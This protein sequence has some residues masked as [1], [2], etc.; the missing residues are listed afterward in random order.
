VSFGRNEPARAR[1]AGERLAMDSFDV[2]RR[3]TGGRS[4]LHDRELT[5][6]VVVPV[7]SLGGPRAT[8]RAVNEALAAALRSLGADVSL[9]STDTV[10]GL[11]AGP[12]FRAPVAGEVVADDRKLVGSAQARIGSALLQH[13]SILLGGDQSALDRPEPTGHS[14]V[15]GTPG[16]TVTLS[17]LVGAVATERVADA[18]V[19]ALTGAFGGRWREDDRTERETRDARSLEVERYGTGEWTWRR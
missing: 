1:Y 15:G 16:A 11:D 13:G 7:I 2:V 3:P 12:C 18:V 14:G 8:Y 10:P 4:V 9:S 5:Y 19:G 17:E 6:A